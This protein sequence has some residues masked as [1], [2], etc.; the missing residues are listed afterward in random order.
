MIIY[1]IMSLCMCNTLIAYFA[2]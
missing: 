1:G 2:D